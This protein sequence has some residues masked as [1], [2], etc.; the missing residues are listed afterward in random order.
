ML[1]TELVAGVPLHHYQAMIYTDTRRTTPGSYAQEMSQ[2][3][4]TVRSN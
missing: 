1:H 4:R 2:P 3:S